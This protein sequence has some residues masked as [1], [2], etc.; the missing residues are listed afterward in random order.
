MIGRPVWRVSEGQRCQANSAA[1]VKPI[2]PLSYT[3]HEV[4]PWC[5]V[6]YYEAECHLHAGRI[7]G[8]SFVEAHNHHDVP[9]TREVSLGYSCRRREDSG[10][11]GQRYPEHAPG[12]GHRSSV[13]WSP[14]LR[15]A[16]PGA[17]QVR[18][19]AS[20]AGRRALHHAHRHQ[21][22][23]LTPGLLRSPVS[24]GS[25]R[26]TGAGSPATRSAPSAQAAPGDLEL[27]AA[28]TSGR[29]DGPPRR[30]RRAGRVPLRGA[31]PPAHHRA[32][33]GT[34]PKTARAAT[35]PSSNRPASY[36]RVSDPPP[37]LD[38][39]FLMAQYESMRARA[40]GD[41]VTRRPAHG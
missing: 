4:A 24:A 35:S 7:F 39:A 8:T 36:V 17:G 15:S 32:G 13:P 33:A 31:A 26:P 3:S 20:G 16:R 28:S 40:V 25:R 14:F 23:L 27:P 11:A 21:L 29:A 30:S 37:K 22:W 12:R 19:A 10:A 18:D 34:T 41:P 5:I 9:V 1:I 2:L 38:S 6:Q